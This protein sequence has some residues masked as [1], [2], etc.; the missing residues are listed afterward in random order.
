MKMSISHQKEQDICLM[1][2][3]EPFLHG[4][5]KEKYVPQEQKVDIEDTSK[6]IFLKKHVRQTY[7]LEKNTVTVEYQHLLKKKI[8]NDKFLSLK[9]PIQIML[10]SRILEADLISKEKVL[11][12]FWNKQSKE[13]SNKLWLPTK[14][15][16]AVSVLTSSKISSTNIPMGKSWFSIT[17]K[18][19]LQ[20]NSLMTS[21]QSSQYSHPDSMVSEAIKSKTKSE[22]KL[23]TLKI[24]LF[25]TEE[26][27][28]KIHLMMEQSRWYYNG[29]ISCLM[30]KYKSKEN[31]IKKD[32]FSDREIRDMLKE[33]SY[34]ED[35]DDNYI[36]KYFA[37]NIND[38][39]QIKDTLKQKLK[40]T[41]MTKEEYI[42]YKNQLKKGK[43]IKQEIFYLN[44]GKKNNHIVV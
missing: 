42:E 5:E 3:L 18:R 15:D 37:R 6:K 9:Q 24:R 7:L 33:Y 31:I 10:L 12:P 2:P 29:L 28:E 4:K 8:W 11:I 39:N 13:M 27:K 21:F 17:E 30:T 35:E 1:C 23:K 26:E 16:Y 40:E 19:P 43:D 44:G 25:P 38:R 41:E 22:T 36:I 32:K 34:V 14:T 20:M